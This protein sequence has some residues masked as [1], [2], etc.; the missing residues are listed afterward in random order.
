[1]IPM[2]KLPRHFSVGLATRVRTDAKS[3]FLI[4]KSLIYQPYAK[5]RKI[6]LEFRKEIR[7]LIESFK[8]EGQLL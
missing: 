3:S 2:Y 6:F 5:E 8:K 1:M 4:S 7:T